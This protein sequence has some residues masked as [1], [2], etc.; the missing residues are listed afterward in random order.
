MIDKQKRFAAFIMPA[1]VILLSLGS[2]SRLSGTENIR[3]IHIV[4]LIAMGMG[5]GLLIRSTVE[6]FVR[7]RNDI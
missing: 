1:F 6:Y 3:P 7:R 5:I 4:T 2:Y